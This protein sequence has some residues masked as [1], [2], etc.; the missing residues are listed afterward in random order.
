MQKRETKANIAHYKNLLATIK[1][2]GQN[3]SLKLSI[4]DLIGNE[5]I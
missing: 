1:L 5:Q 3:S 2:P 4:P